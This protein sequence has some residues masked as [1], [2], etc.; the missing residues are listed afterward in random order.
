[1]SEV[2]LTEVQTGPC[3][4]CEPGRECGVCHGSGRMPLCTHCGE[5]TWRIIGTTLCRDCDTELYL[6]DY[7]EHQ[8]H[9][10]E[11]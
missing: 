9:R 1:M 11:W 7:E 2:T 6:T 4:Y 5:D 3:T 8:R 10:G